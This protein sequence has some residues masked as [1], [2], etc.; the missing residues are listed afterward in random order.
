MFKM[1]LPACNVL[2]LAKFVDSSP[3]EHLFDS[4][5]HA[6]TGDGGAPPNRLQEFGD[7]CG[8]DLGHADISKGLARRI[9]RGTPLTAVLVI[10]ELG[11]VC[12]GISLGTLPKR[13]PTRPF[14]S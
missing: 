7:H 5:A 2:T 1:A 14:A 9:Q 3:I 12:L 6:H 8:I 4:A 10:L 11:E 13:H